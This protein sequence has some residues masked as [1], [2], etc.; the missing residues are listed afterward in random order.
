MIPPA[1]PNKGA[2]AATAALTV[3]GL[4]VVGALVSRP[5][6]APGPV[7]QATA[8]RP[9]WLPD[10]KLS[11]GDVLSNV[12]AKGVCAPGYAKRTRDVT[13]AEKDAVYREYGLDPH[14]HRPTEIDHICSLELAGSNDIKNLFPQ[15]YDSLPY[16]AHLKDKLEDRLHA[17]VCA[18]KITLQQAQDAIRGD[19]TVAYRARFG[20][21]K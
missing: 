10:P 14:N 8:A 18:G 21:P 2:I 4:G 7:V 20:E 16:N 6:Q 19:W 17:E 11:P 13:E 1:Q 5:G 12:T 9:V 3:V 15:P